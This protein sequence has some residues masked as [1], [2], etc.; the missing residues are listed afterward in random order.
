MIKFVSGQK[1][2]INLHGMKYV[3]AK[4]YLE[5]FLSTANGAVKEVHVIHGY[6]TT[7]LKD[8]VRC[9]LVHK[10]I[11]SKTSSINPGVTILHI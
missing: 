11:K 5:K 8:M 10:R 1:V 2:E 4:K 9:D 7:I 3:E 6:S